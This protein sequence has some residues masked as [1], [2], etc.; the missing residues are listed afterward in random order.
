M[1]VGPMMMTIK[2]K[3]GVV[4]QEAIFFWFFF[5]F[6]RDTDF[7]IDAENA[8]SVKQKFG[9]TARRIWNQPNC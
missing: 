6:C 2:K 1:I 7:L 4:E 9:E 5:V 3:C 8:S